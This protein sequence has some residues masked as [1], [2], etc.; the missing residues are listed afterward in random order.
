[1]KF[2]SGFA[3]FVHFFEVGTISDVHQKKT[4]FCRL[5]HKFVFNELKI[6]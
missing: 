3:N 2:N 4:T 5:N 1:M 6:M